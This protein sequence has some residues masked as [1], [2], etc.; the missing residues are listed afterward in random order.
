VLE[1]PRVHEQD[2]E[3]RAFEDLVDGVQY[4]PVASSP[5]SSRDRR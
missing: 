4:T 2:L 5:H 1:V 3:A